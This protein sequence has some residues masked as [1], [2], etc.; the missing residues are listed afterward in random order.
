MFDSRP[1]EL[2]YCSFLAADDDPSGTTFLAET[3]LKESLRTDDPFGPVYPMF[4]VFA[5]SDD[6]TLKRTLYSV[7]VI[8][9]QLFHFCV[10]YDIMPQVKYIHVCNLS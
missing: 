10:C 8:G 1:E 7:M 6:V 5:A 3:C 9:T 2:C 4:L